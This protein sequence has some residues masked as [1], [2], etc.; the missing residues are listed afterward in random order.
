VPEAL[1]FAERRNL[2]LVAARKRLELTPAE[3]QMARQRPNP[4]FTFSAG[5]DNP[6]ESLTWDQ[7]I[8]LGT[9]RRRRIE[10][11]QQLGRVR[12]TDLAAL[13]R[14][15]RRNT[16]EAYY[17]L[18]VTRADAER[19]TDVLKLARRLLE[20]A[21]QRFAAGDIP[22]LE[23][24]QAQLELARVQT[25]LEV[26]RQ[27][28]TVALANLNALINEPASTRWQLAEDLDR[29]PPET[30]LADLQQ[31]AETSNPELQRLDQERAAEDR[32]LAL[33]RAERIPDLSLQTGALLNA[34]KEFDAGARGGFSLV[35]PLFSRNQG[36]IAQSQ[37]NAGILQAVLAATR[38]AVDARVQTAYYDWQ[39]QKTQVLL[40]RQN[41]IPAARELTRRAQESY[42]AG[43]SNILFVLTAQRDAQDVERQYL[44]SVMAMQSAFAAMEEVVGVALD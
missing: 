31:R 14:Q 22:Q 5:R 42:Q 39:A 3:V 35:L 4:T 44:Q 33:L 9:K 37:V 21:E 24:L 18:A 29:L 32:R 15:V 26:A 13:A 28:E 41:L 40:Y 23:V 25:A 34:P 10:L 16:R 43:K 36:Q 17:R 20:I 30:S 27:N 1:E 7:P 12:E 11:A 38:R 8:E 19:L 2:D 6:H